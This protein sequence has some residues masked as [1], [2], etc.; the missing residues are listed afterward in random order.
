MSQEIELLQKMLNQHGF[1]LKVD[2]VNGAKT[3][4]AIRDFQRTVGL[5]VNGTP[6][7]LTMSV[8]Y[9]LPPLP[10]ERPPMPHPDILGSGNTNSMPRMMP[11]RPQPETM[12]GM[13]PAG[14]SGMP[15]PN[16]RP[17]PE[18]LA[19]GHTSM[20]PNLRE[21]IGTDLPPGGHGVQGGPD[22]SMPP[23]NLAWFKAQIGQD[24][25]YKNVSPQVIEFLTK[26][27]IEK[28]GQQP[29]GLAPG[30]QRMGAQIDATG[31]QMDAFSQA[32]TANGNGPF[33]MDPFKFVPGMQPEQPPG[34]PPQ[35][36]GMPP[37][38]PPPGPPPSPP[39]MPPAPP[40]V[41]QAPMPP[42]QP[43]PAPMPPQTAPVSQAAPTNQAAAGPPQAP[44]GMPGQMNDG[45]MGLPGL[46]RTD[47]PFD[48]AIGDP[49][50]WLIQQLTGTPSKA[51]TEK[52]RTS[53]N[54][55]SDKK[56]GDAFQITLDRAA[57]RQ[58]LADMLLTYKSN[59][60][61]GP[62]PGMAAQGQFGYDSF[63]SEIMK[64]LGNARIEAQPKQYIK[65]D[66]SAPASPP[67]GLPLRFP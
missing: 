66:D 58:K 41:A 3:T 20:M 32:K 59:P 19:Q 35:M 65:Q 37:E 24:P 17:P 57:Q 31:A 48:A 28:L 13:S 6:S 53:T 22:M 43:Q 10:K 8:L 16:M 52:D 51:D 61:Q 46:P 56:I 39:Q 55:N 14:P 11:D 25:R 63:F 49:M 21:N 29:Q 44:P 50:R 27:F 34:S 1:D 45:K 5:P 23:D 64:G 54:V 33:N 30:A 67:P 12:Q 9:R 15:S 47:N 26:A 40:Q 62:P 2:G 42:T 18:M 60:G 36:P 7:R 38:Q 4:A